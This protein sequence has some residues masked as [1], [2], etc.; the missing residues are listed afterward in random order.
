VVADAS[1]PI[2]AENVE[3]PKLISHQR[4][5]GRGL[6]DVF[7]FRESSVRLYPRLCRLDAFDIDKHTGTP[8]GLVEILV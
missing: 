4:I 1:E 8:K 3:A 5:R 6:G 7:C 2:L